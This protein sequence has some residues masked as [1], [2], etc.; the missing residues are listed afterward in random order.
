MDQHAFLTAA[1]RNPVNEAI[2]GE[3]FRLALPDAWIDGVGYRTTPEVNPALRRG[4]LMSFF[5]KQCASF[6]T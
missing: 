5:R 3:L 4:G 1:F 6:P 2:A